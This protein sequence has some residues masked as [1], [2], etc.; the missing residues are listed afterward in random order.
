MRNKWKSSGRCYSNA[1]NLQNIPIRTEL[2]RRVRDAVSK[3][4]RVMSEFNY[5]DREAEFH[6]FVLDDLF[7]FDDFVISLF[8]FRKDVRKP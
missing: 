1:P 4:V 3:P 2:G 7:P 8:S 6:D 5:C